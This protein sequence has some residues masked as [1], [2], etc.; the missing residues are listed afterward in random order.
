MCKLCKTPE[1]FESR[2]GVTKATYDVEDSSSTLTE[3]QVSRLRAYA[4]KGHSARAIAMWF[5]V[6]IHAVAPH[7]SRAIGDPS[8][9]RKRAAT[10]A[11]RHR[12][13][14]QESIN[15]SK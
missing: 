5:R 14:N 2:H 7:F 13:V 15:V 11:A 8:I 4:A 1:E 10:F 12:R 6:P 3:E 9:R